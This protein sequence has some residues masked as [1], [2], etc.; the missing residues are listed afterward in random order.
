MSDSLIVRGLT[1]RRGRREVLHGIDFELARGEVLAVIGPNGAGKTSLVRAL[2][3]LTPA[4]SG[5]IEGGG[6]IATALQSPSMARRSALANV[7]LGM[8]WW[9]VPRGERRARADAA[10]AALH[11]GHLARQR[12]DT[13]SG[14]EA[15]RVHLARSLAVA[16]DVLLLDEPFAGL[17]PSTR[18]DLLYDV[19]SALRS[20]DRATLVVVHDRAEAW[21]LADRVVV[22]LDGRIA[23]VGTP[24]EVFEHPVRE[25]VA[26]FV[27]FVGSVR[28]GNTV[29]LFRPAHLRL[30]DAGELSGTVRRR[31]P[32]EDGV[33]IEMTVE[34]GSL[35]VIAPP[36]GP[37]EGETAR[38]TAVGGIEV[39]D[40]RYP[41]GDHAT[42][43][44][45]EAE[46]P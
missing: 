43:G 39:T 46:H 40:D 24:S 25:D 10:L 19:A 5:T 35:V 45:H 33:R 16:P 12:A 41:A 14:G 21:A 26:R 34:G 38:V 3:G 2:A 31:V 23:A 29:R 15:R 28:E 1:V 32:V 17:D 27:G 36:P 20:P 18:A 8:S 22:I 13:L 9:G 7:E 4:Q 42:E 11:A 6:R 44:I 37:A 30:D